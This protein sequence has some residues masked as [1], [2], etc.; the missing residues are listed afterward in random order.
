MRSNH[1]ITFRRPSSSDGPSPYYI[2]F[3]RG[4]DGPGDNT[5]VL[6]RSGKGN[7]GSVLA[8]AQANVWAN[9]GYFRST[10]ASSNGVI[11]LSKTLFNWTSAQSFFFSVTIDP[12][13][14]TK[15]YWGCQGSTTQVSLNR[16]W[17]LI[18]KGDGNP[19]FRAA[20][21]TGVV[22]SQTITGGASV[23]ND[24][25]VAGFFDGGES[26]LTLWLDG[27]E[28][29]S[30]AYGSGGNL[31]P[32]NHDLCF[33]ANGNVAGGTVSFKNVHLLQFPAGV[34][35]KS[36]AEDAVAFTVSSPGVVFARSL[37]E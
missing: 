16:G 14:L 35:V 1:P 24:R 2:S 27:A 30:A 7:H 6:D 17:A 36:Q 9:S 22:F 8:S 28:V 23:G 29:F 13:A 33:G 4:D 34:V 11:A 12:T 37:F 5:Q 21:G 32:P 3:L 31:T 25:A 18:S 26:N 10:A 20:D 15:G 19:L